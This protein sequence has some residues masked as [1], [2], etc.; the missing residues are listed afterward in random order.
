[1]PRK[2]GDGQGVKQDYK[3]LGVIYPDSESYNYFQVESAIKEYFSKWAFCVHDSDIDE[4]GAPVKTHVHWVGVKKSGDGK[5]CPVPI[6]TVSEKIGLEEHEIEFAKSER[7]AIRYLI[8]ADDE[9]KYQ[10]EITQIKCN[11]SLL[12]YFK[13][14]SAA[15]K[16][17]IIYDYIKRERPSCMSQV[18][19][20]VLDNNLYAEFRRGFAIWDTLIKEIRTGND[21]WDHA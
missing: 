17:K 2:R 16:S 1:M 8:H 21:R 20:Y 13:D 7:A 4:T 18:V 6:S 9:D 3:F 15:M 12:K 14:R 11:F 19:D 10:Y 5:H